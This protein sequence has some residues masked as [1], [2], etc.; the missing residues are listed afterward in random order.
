[1]CTSAYNVFFPLTHGNFRTGNLL[2]ASTV[3]FSAFTTGGFSETVTRSEPD[4]APQRPHVKQGPA[5]SCYA[6]LD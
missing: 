4:V 6:L 5:T 1:M 2:D 3:S